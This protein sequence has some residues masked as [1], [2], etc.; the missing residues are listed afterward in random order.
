VPDTLFDRVEEY[1]NQ[2][3]RQRRGVFRKERNVKGQSSHAVAAR[4]VLGRGL[5]DLATG[6]SKEATLK[7]PEIEKGE[8]GKGEE[9]RIGDYHD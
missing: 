4:S 8:E 2:F 3:F 7:S 5:S 1:P 9:I 6:I